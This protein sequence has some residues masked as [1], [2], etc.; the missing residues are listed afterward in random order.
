M[1]E[2]ETAL[3]K[4]RALAREESLAQAAEREM[5]KVGEIESRIYEQDITEFEMTFRENAGQI[6]SLYTPHES[7][8][9]PLKDEIMRYIP[10]SI[11]EPTERREIESFAVPYAQAILDDVDQNKYACESMSAKYI[12]LLGLRNVVTPGRTVRQMESTDAIVGGIRAARNIYFSDIVK[13]H[14]TLLIPDSRPSTGLGTTS[15]HG[16][17]R[18]STIRQLRIPYSFVSRS[19]TELNSRPATQGSSSRALV[20]RDSSRS[21]GGT[22]LTKKRQGSRYQT[23]LP[24]QPF[25]SVGGMAAQLERRN[26]EV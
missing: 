19:Q 12:N 5:M 3:A 16:I 15:N 23:F 11:G 10:K 25:M 24:V 13:S 22:P 18:E 2:K 1:F 4:Q 26:S 21:H 6:R 20:T 17:Q 14:P 9:S 8:F 7:Y